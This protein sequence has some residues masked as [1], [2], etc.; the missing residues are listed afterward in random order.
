VQG[1]RTKAG[2]IPAEWRLFGRAAPGQVNLT[3]TG[4]TAPRGGFGQDEPCGAIRS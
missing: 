3:D 1:L 4:V 2:L